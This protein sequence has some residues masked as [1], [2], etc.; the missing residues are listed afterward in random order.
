M[1]YPCNSCN[2]DD[3][4]PICLGDERCQ[5]TPL[6]ERDPGLTNRAQGVYRKFD[7]R[8]TDGSSEPGGKHHGCEHFV[9]DVTHD[10]HAR[11]ALAA[12]AA[13]VEATHPTLAADMRDRYG[14]AAAAQPSP[15]RMREALERIA[16]HSSSEWPERCQENVRTARTA[17]AGAA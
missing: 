4:Y 5:R 2:R 8:R 11:A 3:G 14:L 17:L 16:Q 15:A 10:P 1:T 6:P 9:L 7:V 13:A 12:Y